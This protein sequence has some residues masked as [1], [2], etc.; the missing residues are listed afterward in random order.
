MISLVV[1][2]IVAIVL[3][4]T[5]RTNPTLPESIL[6]YVVTP[7]QR[8][9]TRSGIYVSNWVEFLRNL[10]EIEN[11]NILLRQRVEALEAENSRLELVDARNERLSLLLDLAQQ[12]ANFPT[13]GAEII[14]KAPGNW[15]NI[16]LIDKGTNHGL[17]RNMVVLAHGGLVG[18]IIESGRN[19]SRVVS[20]IDDTSSISAKSA[21]TNDIGFVRGDT[22]LTSQ[23][24]ARMDYIDN[25]SDILEGDRIVT[26][27][28]SY[29]FP[30]GITIGYVEEVR[31]DA[32][33]LTR[34]AII[35]PTVDF[36]RLET[37]LVIN[38]L[39][40]NRLLEADE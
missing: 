8:V 35:R 39:F 28:L 37:V 15:F 40:E 38:E 3:S 16:F 27:N 4:M 13:V 30:P 21:R 31:T 25:E 36:R 11:E 34:H 12:Y 5:H 32:N 26:S 24:L 10:N 17:D 22:S 19:F 23:G 2:C 18:R 1:V 29:M 14:A 9:F 6:G 33:G 7:I 20:L